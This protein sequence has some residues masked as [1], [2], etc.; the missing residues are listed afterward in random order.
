[1]GGLVL[2]LFL[3]LPVSFSPTTHV[4]PMAVGQLYRVPN[5][6]FKQRKRTSQ[7]RLDKII[8]KHND[9]KLSFVEEWKSLLFAE[10]Q[11]RDTDGEITRG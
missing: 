5:Y 8:R 4:P 3:Q 9:R 6:G 11:R 10:K 7:R 2:L 1:M